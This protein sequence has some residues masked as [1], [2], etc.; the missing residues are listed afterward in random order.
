[1]RYKIKINNQYYIYETKQELINDLLPYIRTQK[2]Y[3]GM[4][5]KTRNM[6]KLAQ[7]EKFN[8][9]IFNHYYTTEDI[10]TVAG[11]ELL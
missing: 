5:R 10:V 6:I 1:M 2:L 7:P 8:M 9:L 3:K 11:G 4:P